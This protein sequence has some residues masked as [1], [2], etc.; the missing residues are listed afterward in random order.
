MPVVEPNPEHAV[1]ERFDDLALELDLFLFLSDHVPL[2]RS[3]HAHDRMGAPAV[4]RR[5]PRNCLGD[6]G[7]VGRLG[8]LRALAL[9]VRDA[10]ALGEGLV[11]L[12]GDARMMHE[13]ILRPLVRGDEPV[14][15]RIVEPLDGSV[16]HEK[17]PPLLRNER[18]RKA[19][20]LR[21]PDSLLLPPEYQQ[22]HGEASRGLARMPPRVCSDAIRQLAVELEVVRHLRRA[23][24]R[25]RS[26]VFDR[27]RHVRGTI[28][29]EVARDG[30]Q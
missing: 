12:T 9:L 27:D 19:L 21:K 2:V 15:L 4:I 28:A 8:A 1:A 18:V 13:Q 3:L 14:P 10:C 5:A 25:P 16:G 29:S 6:R 7:D 30:V 20:F 23:A 26:L 11:T 22:R 24:R 17:T